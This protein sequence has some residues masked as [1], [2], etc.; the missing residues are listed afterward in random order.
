[1]K[2]RTI[3]TVV[4]GAI[5]VLAISATIALI[6]LTTALHDAGLRIATAVDRVRLVMELESRVLQ[7]MAQPAVDAD[8]SHIFAEL[9]QTADAELVADV[10]RLETMID[11]L[12]RGQRRGGEAL[13]A[14]VIAAL[15]SIV[16]REEIETGRAVAAASHWN[17]MANTAGVAIALVLLGSLAAVMIWLW[18]YAFGPLIGVAGA[19]DRL[20]SGD[21]RALAPEEGPEELRKIAV[22]F[23]EMTASLG[24]QHEQQL[25]F[26]G[27]VAHDLRTPLNAL[28][29]GVALLNRRPTDRRTADRIASQV[30]RMERMVDDLLDST[31]I[32]AGRFDLRLEPRDVRDI[33]ARTMEMQ[34]IASPDRSFVV[35]LPDGPV[36]VRCD[37]ARIE[38]VLTNLVSN[39][40]KYSPD[41]SDVEVTLAERGR[42]AALSVA[43]HGVGIQPADRER[44]FEPFSR[45]ENVGRIGGVGLGLSVTRRIVEAHGGDVGVQSTPGRGSVFTV[46]LPLAPSAL[47]VVAPRADGGARGAA[48]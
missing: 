35:S 5:G 43:D 22:A 30:D 4:L 12:T 16:A 13:L 45:G 40:V 47:A 46:R 15:R 7:H 23:N 18:W 17:A 1:M 36:L 32:E 39:A 33:V 20:G 38:R 37:V 48:S 44:I 29:I 6:L 42:M 19:I 3:L 28:R 14:D 41:S 24:R 9:R 25:A 10:A 27:G 8:V 2:L 31:R 21:R 26:V 11:G 34:Q